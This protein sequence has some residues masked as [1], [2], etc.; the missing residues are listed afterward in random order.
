MGMTQSSHELALHS[1]KHSG[2]WGG[3]MYPQVVMCVC[4]CFHLCVCRLEEETEVC[5]ASY[6]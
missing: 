2:V 3:R 5:S 1:S 4:V 6:I